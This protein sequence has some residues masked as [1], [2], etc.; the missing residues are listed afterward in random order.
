MCITETGGAPWGS[1]QRNTMQ[2][3]E[4]TTQ[5][6]FPD[7]NMYMLPFKARTYGC[8]SSQRTNFVRI[9]I[10]ILTLEPLSDGIMNDF[11]IYISFLLIYNLKLFL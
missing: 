4:M 10:E 2:P 6:T 7:T 11:Y 9:H 1:P 8:V 3:F 5:H